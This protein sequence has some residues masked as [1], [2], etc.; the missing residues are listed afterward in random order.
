MDPE[1]KSAIIDLVA[2]ASVQ[3]KQ[4]AIA[5]LAGEAEKVPVLNAQVA[6]K[7]D[8]IARMIRDKKTL[9]QV[10]FSLRAEILTHDG[11]LKAERRNFN[12]LAAKHSFVVQL[13]WL[14]GAVNV[15]ALGILCV[16]HFTPL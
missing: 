16:H 5:R 11:S 13:F 10:I 8:T 9:E 15:I 3:L 12:A 1:I 14:F 4:D 2:R 7:A 6:E